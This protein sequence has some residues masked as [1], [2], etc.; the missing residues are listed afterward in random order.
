[1]AARLR[2]SLKS[3]MVIYIA[4]AAALVSGAA[5]GLQSNDPFMH[6]PA[7][8]ATDTLTER[9]FFEARLARTPRSDI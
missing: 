5:N 7:Y 3:W 4:F 1:M 8:E 6:V 9:R 2:R